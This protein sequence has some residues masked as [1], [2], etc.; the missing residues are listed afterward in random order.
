MKPPEDYTRII[1]KKRYSTRTAT[2]LAGDDYWDGHNYERSGRNSFLYKT[3]KGAYFM[4][5][6]TCWQ[7][8]TQQLQPVELGEAIQFFEACHEGCQRMTYEEAF[9]DVKVEEA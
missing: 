8:E 2:L 7:G 5:H 1:D 4:V 9:P 6:L 3:P